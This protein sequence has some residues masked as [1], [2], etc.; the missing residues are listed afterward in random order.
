M[1]PLTGWQD[2][3]NHSRSFSENVIAI[4]MDR[5]LEHS[6]GFSGRNEKKFRKI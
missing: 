2:A 5:E 1:S 6:Y 4:P 3:L